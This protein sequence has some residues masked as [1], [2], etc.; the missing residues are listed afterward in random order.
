MTNFMIKSDTLDKLWVKMEETRDL[1]VN[2]IK[3]KRPIL[4]RHHAD[5]DG[6]CG[7]IALERAIL[8]LMYKEY[9]RESDLFYYYK[10]LP[11]KAPF[12]DYMDATKDLS[13]FL[14]DSARFERTAPLIVVIDNGSSREDLLSLQKL[15]IYDAKIIVIDHHPN[16]PDNDEYIDVHVNPFLV[17]A[18]SEMVAGMLCAEIAC[19][20]DKDIQNPE[21][22][23]ATAGIADH[24][25]GT[26]TEQYLGL[27]EKKGFNRDIIEK[28]AEVIDF[29]AKF[30]SFMESRKLV[31]DLLYGDSEKHKQ[32]VELVQ[33]E[34]I[35]RNEKQMQIIK[36]YIEIIDKNSL[37]IAKIN[38]NKLERRKYPS[39]SKTIGMM[40]RY[41]QEKYKKPVV[42]IGIGD[43]IITFR[44]SKELDFDVNKIIKA[45][46]EKLPH[47][48]VN[49]GGHPKAGTVRFNPGA[50]KEVY[51]F[52]EDYLKKG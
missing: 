18:G 42:G 50:Y 20:I 27:A 43:D 21:V 31:N 2:S 22:L 3:N 4:I 8:S 32:L 14:T 52:I 19:L 46:E 9:R 48:D 26:E 45:L 47:A 33:K 40:L 23:A 10:R 38:L 12:Y 25:N 16:S 29:E 28:T 49:G 51:L 34:I 35:K 17:G 13:N 15:K 6:Y 41:A 7:A 5:C 24:S 44:I 39:N 30:I 36:H 37:I 11:S 1:I